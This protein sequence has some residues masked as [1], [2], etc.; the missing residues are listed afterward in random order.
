MY[1]NSH[2]A[3]CVASNGTDYVDFNVSVL[4]YID[5]AIEMTVE[6][7][8]PILGVALCAMALVQL[9]LWAASSFSSLIHEQKQFHLSRQL[10]RKQIEAAA[11]QSNVAHRETEN[12][13]WKGFRQFRVHRIAKETE[14]CTSVYLRPI[15]NK[16]ICDFLPGQ[17]LTLKFTVPGKQKP[18]VRCY[19]LSQ[20]PSQRE[21]RISVK[22]VPPPRDNPQAPAGLVSNFVNQQLV[23]G[24]LVEIKAPSGHFHL[25][26]DADFPVV[27]LAGGV[28]ITPLLSMIDFV[29]ARQPARQVVLF[30]GSR[31]G[32]DHAFKSYLAQVQQQFK[33]IYIVNA[34]SDPNSEDVQGTDFHVKGFISMD[35][36]KQVLPNQSYH[37]YMCGPPPFM[38]SVYNGLSEWGIP[39]SRIH[40]EAFGPASIG[41]SRNKKSTAEEKSTADDTPVKFVVSNVEAVFDSDS[42][43]LLECAEAN[44]VNVDSGC[45]AGNCGTCQVAIKSGKVCYPDGQEVDCDPGHCLIC[46]AKPDGP[47]ELEA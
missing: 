35:L 10:L 31:N 12:G 25:D 38:D 46:V 7:L 21:Y 42:D 5:L 34:Y 41:K 3:T 45:R 27:L 2:S 14:L 33:N 36:I 4:F 8:L 16:P 20:G 39:E 44:G 37:F 19:S 18:V 43:N 47:V 29:I 15:D 6:S 11:I 13:S 40:F 26:V 23:Q 30:Y 24:D 9:G 28:G 1:R 32:A 17:H 22:A